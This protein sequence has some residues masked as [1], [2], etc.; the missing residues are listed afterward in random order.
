MAERMIRIF[1]VD[2]D[3]LDYVFDYNAVQTDALRARS[4]DNVSLEDLRRIALWKLDRVVDVSESLLAQLRALAG[5]E[6]LTA[7]SEQSRQVLDALVAC[8]GVGYPM[9]SA[10]LK[11]VRPDVYPIIDVRAYRALTGTRLRY[12]QYSTDLYLKYVARV[13]EIARRCRMPLA[14]VDEQLYCYDKAH[15]GSIDA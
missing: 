6:G 13:A 9:A 15:N 2:V 1:D 8:D 11:F 4:Y 12:N 10:F 5:A 7:D 3:A 14:A